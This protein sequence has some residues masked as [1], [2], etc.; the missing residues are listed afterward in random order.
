MKNS[1][2]EDV[3]IQEMQADLRGAMPYQ[4]E[5]VKGIIEDWN[6]LLENIN[7]DKRYQKINEDL[8]D[9][10]EVLVFNCSGQSSIYESCDRYYRCRLNDLPITFEERLKRII[11]LNS[12]RKEYEMCRTDRIFLGDIIDAA[13]N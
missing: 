6:I 2:I 8:K 3:S 7:N 9:T 12:A 11:E 1:N 13:N 10:I 5:F 4:T